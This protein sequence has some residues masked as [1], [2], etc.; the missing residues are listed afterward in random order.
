MRKGN[1]KRSTGSVYVSKM[2]S[3]VDKIFTDAYSKSWCHMHQ[4]PNILGSL[5]VKLTGFLSMAQLQW[6]F[7]IVFGKCTLRF[8]GDTMCA[9]VPLSEPEGDHFHT[10]PFA[11]DV[12][13]YRYDFYHWHTGWANATSLFFKYF[14]D[15]IQKTNFWSTEYLW[16]P[17]PR[18]S[19]IIISNL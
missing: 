6:Q 5:Q 7:K 9:I 3:E 14:E 19:I 15:S 11:F 13:K 10:S 8:W 12:S 17:L 1:W 16:G 18:S 2:V 4:T